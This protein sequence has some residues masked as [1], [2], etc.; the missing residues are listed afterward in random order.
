[1]N[2]RKYWTDQEITK[3]KEIYPNSYSE[4]VAKAFNCSINQVYNLAHRLNVKKSDAWLKQELQRQ[5]E[6]LRIV[7]QK[8]RFQP[9]IIP[10]NKGQK[11]SKDV[12]DRVKATFFTKGHK[13]HNIKWDGY[14]R[15][16]KDGY[17]MIRIA[18]GKFKLKHRVVWE[19]INGPVPLGM[20]VVFK[21]RNK[22]N[23]DINN[24]ELISFKDN[25]ER[26]RMTKYPPEL[27]N[28]IKLNNKLKK[29]LNEK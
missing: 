4:D 20:I 12:Y 17:V 14:E 13:P 9:G 10:I 5:A 28:I 22:R 3:F 19:E 1:M 29:K 7:G 23:F 18:E 15:I 11:M 6:R 24:L 2:K 8:S 16:D 21:D 26:N 27:R 25:M